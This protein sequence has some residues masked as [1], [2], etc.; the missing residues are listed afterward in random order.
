MLTMLIAQI[1]QGPTSPLCQ[2]VCNV[3]NSD[4]RN[5]EAELYLS[6]SKEKKKKTTWSEL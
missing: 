4:D 6:V 5:A 3:E 1:M 2:S